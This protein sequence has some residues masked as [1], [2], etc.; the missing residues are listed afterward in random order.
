[1]SIKTVINKGVSTVFKVL[2]S[3]VYP[4]VYTTVQ[5]DGFSTAVTKDYTV[6][7]IIDSFSER[8]VQFLSFSELIQPQDV[9]GLIRGSQLPVYPSS[10]DFLVVT[11]TDASNGKYSVIASSTD[12]AFALYTVL[13]R[14]V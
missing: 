7:V 6:D 14:R 4:A 2:K 10:K 13:L 3:I 12:P 8:D 11:S 5:D 9:K 1:M